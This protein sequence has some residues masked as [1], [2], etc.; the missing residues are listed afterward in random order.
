M[1]GSRNARHQASIINRTNVCGG[2]KKPGLAPSVGNFIS[3]N[4]NL[5]GAKNTVY[6]DKCSIYM[7]LTNQ[8]PTQRYGY[9]ATHGGNM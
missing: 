7:R 2:I 5:I 3:S 8:H 1:S 4:P 9:S 6:G